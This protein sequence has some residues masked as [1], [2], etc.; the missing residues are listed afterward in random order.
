MPLRLGLRSNR[1]CKNP[2]PRSVRPRSSPGARRAGQDAR[3]TAYDRLEEPDAAIEEGAARPVEIRRL[4]H[5]SRVKARRRRA[6]PSTSPS[7][8]VV[9]IAPIYVVGAGTREPPGE[10]GL[11][12]RVQERR[13]GRP[14][15]RVAAFAQS[16][17]VRVL[18]IAP[19]PTS[20]AGSRRLAAAV[21]PPRDR[22]RDRRASSPWHIAGASRCAYGV[23][24]AHR[25]TGHHPSMETAIDRR[26]R[27][28]RSG[29]RSSEPR[30]TR[31]PQARPADDVA[32]PPTPSLRPDQTIEGRPRP[33]A[34]GQGRTKGRRRA[35]T[36]DRARGP[37][38]AEGVASR[39]GRG[40]AARG[41]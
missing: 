26:P 25:V 16:S 14:G 1:A 12:T 5:A 30:R 31:S 21:V 38:S 7:E 6:R 22:A 10:L 17:G 2:R 27:A 15:V 37:R 18:T 40:S 4:A 34:R 11:A 9:A 29:I 13:Q 39:W 8:I 19:P 28:G 32:R 36:S 41:Y 23:D 20:L 33:S 3:W 35:A 24:E